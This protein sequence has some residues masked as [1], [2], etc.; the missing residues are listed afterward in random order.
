MSVTDKI[1][2]LEYDGNHNLLPNLNNCKYFAITFQKLY[3]FCCCQLFVMFNL[4]I[5]LVGKYIYLNK[6]IYISKLDGVALLVTSPPRANFSFLPTSNFLLRYFWK[7]SSYNMTVKKV[8][9]RK[10]KF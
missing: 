6:C 10:R 5:F 4:A 2:A 3:T 1:F 8:E 9:M 7:R